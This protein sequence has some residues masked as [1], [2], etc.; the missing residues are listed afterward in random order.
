MSNIEKLKQHLREDEGLRLKAYLE[1]TTN[2]W[3][4][5]YG[6]L[7][8][9]DQT[10]VELDILGLDEELDDWS[11]L[12]VTEEQ[13]EELLSVDIHDAVVSLTP[14]WSEEDLE[15][16]NPQR[17]IALMSMC[18]QMGG[19]KIQNGFPSFTRAVLQEDWD[20]AGDEM[21]WRDGLKQEVRSRWYK[22]TP[23]RCQEMSDWMK[24]GTTEPVL[25]ESEELPE[26]DTVAIDKKF[27]EDLMS[28]TNKILEILES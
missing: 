16:L 17:F 12:T 11:E 7:L 26:K 2:K 23:G 5:A 24:H 15:N 19:H 21:L 20:R 27:F 10:D 4:I 25:E 14:T 28:K 9:Q 1:T 6:H 13:A 22:Q 18:F 8:D 3:H